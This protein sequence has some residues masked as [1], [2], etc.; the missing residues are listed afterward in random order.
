MRLKITLLSLLIPLLGLALAGPATARPAEHMRVHTARVAQQ[1]RKEILRYA[2]GQPRIP[3]TRPTFTPNVHVA[4]FAFAARV[5]LLTHTTTGGFKSRMYLLHPHRSNGRLMIYH[6]GHSSTI[7][8]GAVPSYLQ[9]FVDRGY[10]VLALSMLGM[11]PK[12]P[13]PKPYVYHDDLAKLKHPLRPFL[14]PVAVGLN[15]TLARHH[16]RSVS[17]MGLSGGGWTTTVYSAIDERIQRSYPVAGSYPLDLAPKNTGDFEQHDPRLMSIV[18]YRDL[19]AM[20][21]TNGRRQLQLLNEHDNCC[22]YGLGFRQ[23]QT[24]VGKVARRLGGRYSVWLD[25][26]VRVHSVSP[27]A[28]AVIDRDNRS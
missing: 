26:R 20:A 22:F 13:M 9:Y 14:E 27:A 6:D 4:Q 23:W 1:A 2:F 7:F 25:R 8:M 28:L 12:A 15:E 17:M 24:P 3:T 18:G 19:Y 10:T 5:D 21:A 16:Y 11:D